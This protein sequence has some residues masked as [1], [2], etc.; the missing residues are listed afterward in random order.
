MSQSQQ[1]AS[2]YYLVVDFYL[3]MRVRW[4]QRTMVGFDSGDI[5]G[6][7]PRLMLFEYVCNDKRDVEGSQVSIAKDE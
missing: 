6:V 2:L 7:V 3:D 1:R 4:F 5:E